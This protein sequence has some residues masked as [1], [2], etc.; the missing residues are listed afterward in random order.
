MKERKKT[1]RTI[2][3]TTVKL[4]TK[5]R[6]VGQLLLVRSWDSRRILIETLL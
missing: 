3:M 2:T 1:M 5:K 4:L 6:G